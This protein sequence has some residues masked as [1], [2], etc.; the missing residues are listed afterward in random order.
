MAE[1]TPQTS[2]L[3][4]PASL[5]LS[6]RL[7]CRDAILAHCNLC[8]LS[9][10]NSPASASHVAWITGASLFHKQGI[11]A[12]AVALPRAGNVPLRPPTAAWL[13]PSGPSDHCSDVIL[14][15][16]FF[17]PHSLK[18]PRFVTLHAVS[19]P[20]SSPL[21]RKTGFCHVGQT[22]LQLLT[23]GDPPA[24]ASQSAGIT[25]VSHQARPTHSILES[26]SIK[27][28]KPIA[29][30]ITLT[31]LNLSPSLECNHT[32]MAH[33]SLDFLAS[34]DPPISGSR[35]PGTTGMCHCT[36]LI[37]V[38][39]LYFVEMKFCHVAQG[40][41]KLV[42]V[43]ALIQG[44]Q[45]LGFMLYQEVAFFI[46]EQIPGRT[47]WG[48]AVNLQLFF[49]RLD[50]TLSPRLECS[51]SDLGS[52]EPPPPGLKLECNGEISAYRNLC[53]PGSSDSPA[54]ASRVAGITGMCHH[55]QLIF[56]FLVKT[57]FYHVGRAGLELLTFAE[58]L[59]PAGSR[60]RHSTRALSTRGRDRKT[61]RK[62]LPDGS[63]S[64]S[65]FLRF[66][67]GP[68]PTGGLQ[69]PAPGAR[70]LEG[71]RNYDR[72]A[73]HT[74]F[75]HTRPT[76]AQNTAMT[77]RPCRSPLPAP[78]SLQSQVLAPVP[79]GGNGH[80]HPTPVSGV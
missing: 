9:S 33:C 2:G 80:P 35:V 59:R 61:E 54:L 10:S 24:L 53:L 51:G 20:A 57:V 12:F 71:V 62:K 21:T 16:V 72:K 37:F 77:Q 70:K 69:V 6:P 28:I 14:L 45:L 58:F 44:L 43:M 32:I 68:I 42:L 13:P 74:G 49:L 17:L 36:W 5:A 8:L 55:A 63:N 75:G 7:E 30:K 11:R 48:C 67:S 23:S 19:L 73:A 65:N 60:A 4:D 1:Q 50:L 66:E 15:D 46:L 25:S 26:F 22:G 3:L 18:Q 41:L 38:Y 47:G 78:A 29:P 39:F 56:I 27:T 31:G 64:P 34:C 52:L 79:H 76:F 40:G